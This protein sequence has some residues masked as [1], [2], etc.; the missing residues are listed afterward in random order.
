[1]G[2]LQKQWNKIYRKTIPRRVRERLIKKLI[3]HD[4]TVH[5]DHVIVNVSFKNFLKTGLERRLQV[6]LTNGPA[7]YELDAH[8]QG[9]IIG[10][11]IPFAVIDQTEGQSTIKMML[12][13]K[14]LIVQTDVD[15][16]G[17]KRS[18][19]SNRRY[20]NI[21]IARGNLLIAN[22]L[23]DYRFRT[24][25]PVALSNIEA[26]YRRL[27]LSA[28]DMDDLSGHALAFHYGNKL[29][30]MENVSSDPAVMQITDFT[31]VVTG[32]PD[33][34]LLKDFEL[35]PIRYTGEPLS[36]AALNHAITY[37]GQDGMLSAEITTHKARVEAFESALLDDAVRM[38]FYT[39]TPASLSALLVADTASDDIVRIPFDG[40]QTGE[41]AE[42]S[43]P[44]DQLINNMSR[45]RLMF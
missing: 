32:Q 28:E 24:D 1:M 27:E 10:I 20:F 44:L 2:V 12:G 35:V 21:S 16:A 18:F 39:D 38:R 8:R 41:A 17:K 19:F 30:I 13:K 40:D 42:V 37:F 25:Q 3:L 29:K 36:V 34:Y 23:S 4:I 45:K 26:G 5:A 33:V 14:K 31:D 7:I 9:H 6:T 15:K 43:V 11:E 22:L